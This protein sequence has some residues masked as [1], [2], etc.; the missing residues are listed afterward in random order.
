M[1]DRYFQ[2][3]HNLSSAYFLCFESLADLKGLRVPKTSSFNYK[4]QHLLDS[5]VNIILLNLNHLYQLH[6]LEQKVTFR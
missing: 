5:T 1:F 2:V 6:L 3:K 4:Y